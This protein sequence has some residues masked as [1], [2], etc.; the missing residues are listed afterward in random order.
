MTR[1]IH[2]LRPFRLALGAGLIL[3]ALA[4]SLAAAD[5]ASAARYVSMGDSYSA[6]TGLEESD[7]NWGTA[8]TDKDCHRAQKAYPALIRGALGASNSFKFAACTGARTNHITSSGQHGNPAQVNAEGVGSDTVDIT[9]SIG[10]NDAGFGDVLLRCGM[11]LVSCNT[12]INDAQSHINNTL[13][14]QLNSVYNAIKAK[15]PNARVGVLG[16]PRLFPADGDD[17]SAATFFS[18]DEINRLNQTADMLADTIRARARAHGFTFIDS[19]PAFLGHAWCENEWINGLSNPTHKSF[20]PNAAGYQGF[21]DITRAAMLAAPTRGFARGPNGRLAFTAT[22][23]GN[24]EIYTVNADGSHPVNLTR[25]A[26][27]DEAPVFSPDGTKIAFASNRAGT[28]TKFDIW[29]M[30]WDGSNPRRLTTSTG[31]DYDPSWSP[32]G[33]QIVFRS[34][35]DGDN[36]I[37]KMNADGTNLWD[38]AAVHQLTRNTASDFLPSFSPDGAEIVFQRYTAGSSTGQGN[39]VMKMNADGQGQIN[40]TNNASNI[41]DGAPSFS[42][43]GSQIVFHSNRNGNFEIYTMG[44]TGGT[45]TRRT[46]NTV[47]DRNPSYSPNGS[48]ITFQSV[49]DGASRIYTMSSSGTSQTRRTNHGGSDTTPSWQGDSRNPESQI[50]AGPP[51][52]TNQSTATFEFTSDEPGSSFQC[53]LSGGWTSCVS[54]FS[55]GSLPD[56]NHTFRVRAVD[57]SGNTEST[58]SSRSFEIDTQAKV[59]EILA[60]PSGPTNDP[61]VTFSFGSSASVT[62]ECRVTGEGLAAEWEDCASPWQPGALEDGSYRFE[63][64]AT[65]TV[66]NVEDPPQG[67]DFQVDTVAPGASVASGPEPLS[68][69]TNP[70]F[71]LDSDEEGVTFECSLV[72]AGSEPDWQTC[73]TPRETGP[74]DDG[75]WSFAV[76]AID[77]AGNTGPASMPHEFSVDTVAPDSSV[78]SGPGP[79]HE[80]GEISVEFLSGDPTAAFECRLD[81]SDDADWQPCESPFEADGLEHGQHQVEIRATDPAGNVQSASTV[82]TFGVFTG[83]NY[84]VTTRPSDPT[85]DNRPIFDVVSDDP[86]ATFRCKLDG[87]VTWLPC[88]EVYDPVSETPRLA[89][90]RHTM[91]IMATDSFGE[92]TELDPISWVIDTTPTAI[93]ILSGPTRLANS[94]TATFL[95]DPVRPGI[96][97]MCRIDG[98]EWA[99]CPGGEDDGTPREVTFT[100][101]LDADHLLEV[102]GEGS[103]SGAGPIATYEWTVDAT[104][105]IV[106]LASGPRGRVASA[107]A[108]FDFS[109]TEQG[110]SFECRLD[111]AAFAPCAAPHGLTGLA[112]GERR[113]EVRASDP[114]GNV[115]APVARTWTVDTTGPWVTLESFPASGSKA[116][117]GRFEFSSDEPGA[118]SCQ[119]DGSGWLPCRSPYTLDIAPGSHRFEVRATDEI[120]NEGAPVAHQW[121]AVAPPVK[122]V[123]RL[124]RAVRVG[125]K[126]KVQL[127]T[128]RCRSACQITVP[129]RVRVRSGRVTVPAR[130]VVPRR[131]FAGQVK[132]SLRIPARLR[133]ALRSRPGNFRLKIVARGE[134]GKVASSV[135]VKLRR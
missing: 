89:D 114:A 66:G 61:E 68:S 81:S 120:G 118:F 103:F 77:P 29:V 6:G 96:D 45:V 28:A 62:F 135:R 119:L 115:S 53:Q 123:V 127:A 46:N 93:Q 59:T 42:P 88:S 54:P 122:P 19:R 111:G 112:D 35:R 56:G 131:R 100:G 110:A 80:S 4:L 43:D 51:A 11:P 74:L 95:I 55:T 18:A 63:V 60:G 49:R 10:G 2:P 94:R 58:P 14:G 87:A 92:E 1:R 130:L 73:V 133:R 9:I 23:D 113:F 108:R 129:K 44:A 75:E 57:P 48:Q 50:T 5:P 97:L 107:S 13:P 116:G 64:R 79:R 37:F 47:D 76:R 21:A 70:V 30:D 20:H 25:N 128:I 106:S 99:R 17:C 102:R 52:V 105:P 65:D 34:D 15:A 3:V 117:K 40:L 90:G 78:V 31:D 16:Y 12:E 69:V 67:L 24:A 82:H 27:S 22:R 39:E 98:W 109:T 33:K 41:N 101:L 125:R 86:G 7:H 91:E 71:E 36:E 32:N 132:V 72:R 124:N 104:A 38:G 121:Q 134:A 84:Q 85:G 83:P 126:A 8:A 26:A